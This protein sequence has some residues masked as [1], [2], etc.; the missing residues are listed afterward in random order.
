MAT[1]KMSW[2]VFSSLSKEGDCIVSNL[3]L[4][5]LHDILYDLIYFFG[6]VLLF[7]EDFWKRCWIGPKNRDK[8]TKFK[9][10]FEI[11]TEICHLH[12][13]AHQHL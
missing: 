12:K 10:K 7:L 8:T 1:I 4:I 11:K 3:W 5:I 13:D 2:I 6:L 9:H